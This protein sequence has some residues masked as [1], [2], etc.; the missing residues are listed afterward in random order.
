M[1]MHRIPAMDALAPAVKNVSGLP[2]RNV[3]D[4]LAASW[5]HGSWF[6]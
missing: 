1:P 3:L 5:I 4:D 6:G 2:L